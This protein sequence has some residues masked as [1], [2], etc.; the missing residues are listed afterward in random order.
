MARQN[1]A[2]YEAAAALPESQRVRLIK[3]LLETL[4]DPEAF[5]EQELGAELN[6]RHKEIAAG[7][8]EPVSWA[9][10]KKQL[11]S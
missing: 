3:N 4:A 6:R 11:S 2:L 10:L 5:W 8:A 7:T 9:E 1:R